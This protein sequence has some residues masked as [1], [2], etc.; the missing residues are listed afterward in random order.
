MN[1]RIVFF[2]IPI[3]AL[4]LAF[5]ACGKAA[6]EQ[7][8]E[9]KP[10]QETITIVQGGSAESDN[11][12]SNDA[13]SN[14]VVS[15]WR[16]PPENITE[17]PTTVTEATPDSLEGTA[18]MLKDAD[19]SVALFFKDGIMT[20]VRADVCYGTIYDYEGTQLE[21][22]HEDDVV[23]GEAI[24]GLLYVSTKDRDGEA[25]ARWS[26][27]EDVLQFAKEL[28]GSFTAPFTP[29]ALGIYFDEP[30]DEDP[31]EGTEEYGDERLAV[32]DGYVPFACD[33]F[34][35]E[36]PADWRVITLNSQYTVYTIEQP[37]R[38]G[39][40]YCYIE[41]VCGVDYRTT[42]EERY[43]GLTESNIEAHFYDS[44]IGGQTV[45]VLERASLGASATEIAAV[46]PS[47]VGYRLNFYCP[48]EDEAL[49]FSAIREVM[50]HFTD[51]I[52]FK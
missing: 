28:N 9:Q 51:H 46:T 31:Y 20:F 16:L 33:L 25:I 34:T 6:T 49:N 22:Y 1:K 43:Q 48:D 47:G 12:Q 27:I 35:T 32:S 38:D 23:F 7:K 18:W 21:A 14:D 24:E 11:S 39:D 40:A 2:V 3:V 30:Y 26:T 44:E 8:T 10:E 29:E 50:D 13:E 15:G 41:V 5:I 4:C 36:I 19:N 37:H 45:K 42:L 52:Q 17:N